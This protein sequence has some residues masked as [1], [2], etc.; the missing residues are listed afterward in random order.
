MT[1]QHSRTHPP[2]DLAAMSYFSEA[3][4]S[5]GTSSLLADMVGGIRGRNAGDGVTGA[6]AYQDGH[7][8]QWIEGPQTAVARLWERIRRDPRHRIQ[9]AEPATRITGRHFSGSPMRLALTLD[10]LTQG[11]QKSL[12]DIF[13]LPRKPAHLL[14]DVQCDRLS[15]AGTDSCDCGDT[16]A[17]T[18]QMWHLDSV[19]R[20]QVGAALAA[21]ADDLVAELVAPVRDGI[22]SNMLQTVRLSDLAVLA[23]AVMDRLQADWMADRLSAVQCQHALSVLQSALRRLLDAAEARRTIGSAM[24]TLLPGTTDLAGAMLKVALLRRAGWSVKLLLPAQADEILAEAQ[25][26]YPDLIVLAGSRMVAKAADLRLLAR[27][28]P[29]LARS[30]VRSVIVGGKLAQTEPVILAAYGVTA[31]CTSLADITALASPYAVLPMGAVPQVMRR[32]CTVAQ[33]SL[34]DAAL[35][36]LAP[37]ERGHPRHNDNIVR[38]NA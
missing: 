14:L 38:L 17:T 32:D 18:P 26:L 36:G 22:C 21:R 8:R 34:V 16:G 12:D 24:V 9:W 1:A 7:I 23:E 20:A 35:R 33:Q 5:L 15:C 13:A 30:D 27:L 4:S 28:V 37:Q 19:Y 31:L 10:A 11:A 2:A 29:V 6:I 25:A 3:G